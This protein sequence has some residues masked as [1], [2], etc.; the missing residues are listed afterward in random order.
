MPLYHGEKTF[1]F[2]RNERDF[3][4]GDKLI[5]KEV[6]EKG[7]YTG[8]EVEKTI[9]YVLTHDDFMFVPRGYAVLGI[10]D[11]Y[12]GILKQADT[13]YCSH[14]ELIEQTDGCFVPVDS[15]G[16]I[17]ENI[18]AS[19]GQGG[20]EWVFRANFCPFCGRKR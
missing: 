18:Q 2:R 10:Q 12:Y 7:E 20:G 17:V 16:E 4:V 6:D 11:Y 3:K 19:N 14:C 13:Q 9:S 8:W 5:L 1:E 15:E